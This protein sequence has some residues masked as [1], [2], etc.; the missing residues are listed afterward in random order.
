MD[1]LKL[2]MLRQLGWAADDAMRDLAL[3]VKDLLLGANGRCVR[4]PG[5]LLLLLK[6]RSDGILCFEDRDMEA[7]RYIYFV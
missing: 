4:I 5:K 6:S 7:E 1:A 3:V 2:L